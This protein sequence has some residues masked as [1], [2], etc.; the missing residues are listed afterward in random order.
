MEER[1]EPPP[2][3]TVERLR[4]RAREYR[5][6]VATILATDIREELLWMAERFEAAAERRNADASM[7]V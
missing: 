5:A 1:Y 7:A 3:L 6:L 2:Y 4:A